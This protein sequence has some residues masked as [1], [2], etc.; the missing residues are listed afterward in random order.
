MELKS[1]EK[2][3]RSSLQS[4]HT[5]INLYGW[6]GRREKEIVSYYCFGHLIG[7]CKPKSFLYDPRQICIEVAVPQIAGQK[8]LS[9]K[10]SQ[11]PQVCKDI[12]LW[13]KPGLTC[14]DSDGRAAVY[15]SAIIEWKHNV[16]KKSEYDRQWLVQF[17]QVA[18]DFVGYRVTTELDA[19]PFQLCC[20]RV[21]H[22]ETQDAWFRPTAGE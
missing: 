9:G 4:L 10:K 18:N 12:V 21:Q 20:D 17:S 8:A 15:P 22:G 13:S 2:A 14:W 7:H 5:Q 3:I 19:G 6:T 1:L 11:K 16:S